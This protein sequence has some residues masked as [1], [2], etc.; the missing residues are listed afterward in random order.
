MAGT[1]SGVSF[2]ANGSDHDMVLYQ[3]KTVAFS[4][5]WGGASPIDVTGYDARMQIRASKSSSSAIAEFTVANSRVSVGTTN[6]LISFSMTAADS[7]ALSAGNYVYD[8]EVIDTSN[9]V[10][11]AMSGACK[12][13]GEVTK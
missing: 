1:V 4:L 7:A 5:T 2:T 9:A 10:L 6:G 3:G 11:L 12:I 13:V 8:I